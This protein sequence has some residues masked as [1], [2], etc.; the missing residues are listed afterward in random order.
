MQILNCLDLILEIIEP[1]IL[2]DEIFIIHSITSG[3]RKMNLRL[4][5]FS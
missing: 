5:S 2:P 1:Q 3:F 4:F